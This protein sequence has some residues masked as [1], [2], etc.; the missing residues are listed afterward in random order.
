MTTTP[1]LQQ[2][3]NREHGGGCDGVSDHVVWNE[4]GG[5]VKAGLMNLWNR[6]NGWYEN[7]G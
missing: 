7:L 5:Y 3:P 6:Y 4:V 2:D 1:E